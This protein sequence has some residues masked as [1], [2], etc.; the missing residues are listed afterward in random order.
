[1]DELRLLFP[2]CRLTTDKELELADGEYGCMTCHRSHPPKLKYDSLCRLRI[3]F[4]QW[5]ALARE[6]PSNSRCCK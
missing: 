4:T 6:I 2:R 1:M 5:F 3:T